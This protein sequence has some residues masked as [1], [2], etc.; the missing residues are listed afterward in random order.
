[1]D[2]PHVAILGAGPVGICLALML[3]KRGYRVTVFEKRDA[4]YRGQGRAIN[5][6]LSYKGLRS[7]S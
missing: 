2:R 6:S 7:L 4:S 1:M 5:L 3:E